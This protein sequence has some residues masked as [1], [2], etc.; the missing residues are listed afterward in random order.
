MSLKGMLAPTPSFSASCLAIHQAGFWSCGGATTGWRSAAQP[1]RPKPVRISSCRSRKVVSG[2]ITSAQ[3][4][5][6]LGRVSH[7]TSR[8]RLLDGLDGLL[9]RSA[10]PASDSSNRRTSP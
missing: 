9:L 4:A 2:R 8:S 3:P 5:I 6:S 1:V 7:T 10:A